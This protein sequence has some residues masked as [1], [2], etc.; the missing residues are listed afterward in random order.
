MLAKKRCYMYFV[1]TVIL[2]RRLTTI[3]H[4]QHDLYSMQ[5]ELNKI[6]TINV[7]IHSFS[8]SFSFSSRVRGMDILV[9]IYVQYRHIVSSQITKEQYANLLP[10]LVNYQQ[11]I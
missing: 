9:L 4:L 2:C 11:V 7:N 3:T 8:F 1:S 6:D 10:R 5:P